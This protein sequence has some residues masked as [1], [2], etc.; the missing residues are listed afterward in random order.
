MDAPSR[1]DTFDRLRGLWQRRRRPALGVFAFIAVAAVGFVLGLPDV[2]RAQSSILVDRANLPA[3]VAA[4]STSEE[5]EA[6]IGALGEQTLSRARLS[7]LIQRF[8][9]YPAMAALAEDDV[10]KQMRRDITLGLDRRPAAGNL[11]TV[12]LSVAYRGTSPQTVAA[13]ANAL[14]A[15][16]V[17][18]GGDEDLRQ[19]S[20]AADLLKT[21]MDDVKRKMEAQEQL[22]REYKA[23]HGGDLPEQLGANL[24]T[25][26]R[27]NSQIERNRDWQQRIIERRDA[28]TRYAQVIAAPDTPLPPTESLIMRLREDLAQLRMKYS[29]SYPDVVRLKSRLAAAEEAAL[30]A[31]P[32]PAPAP[33]VAAAPPPSANEDAELARL[34][35]EEQ[36]LRGK[37]AAYQSRI[38]VAPSRDQELR[39]L[40]RDYEATKAL[41]ASLFERDAET[42]LAGRLEQKRAG[43]RFRVLDAAVPPAKPLGPDRLRLVLIALA[44]ALAGALTTALVLER[45][46]TT[47]HSTEQL[48][49]ARVPVVAGIPRL[50]ITSGTARRRVVGTLATAGGLAALVAVFF[51]S[52]QAALRS[53]AV[54]FLALRVGS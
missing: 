8:H 41:Y 6:K 22:I 44:G 37:V 26:E 23:R 14:A 4:P 54:S 42:R 17:D 16:F 7:E 33:K 19:S 20:S 29:E 32:P 46:D 5:I 49:D 36:D 52:Y 43:E 13:V 34:R 3:S 24:A 2:Y 9:L 28:A 10:V 21:Q 27:L 11:A 18:G 12:S 39:E 51:V 47:F 45:L 30:T 38:E 15:Y 53:E 35:D 40:T 50:R 48:R 31:P 25:L 1:H